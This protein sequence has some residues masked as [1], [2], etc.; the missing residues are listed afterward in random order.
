M[1]KT[2]EVFK[3]FAEAEEADKKYYRSLSPNE[4]IALL[5]ILRDQY[6]PYSHE[7]TEDLREFIELLSE[8]E[9]RFLIVGAFAVAYHGYFRYTSDIDLY[10]TI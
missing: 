10:R 3:S 1:K 6:R 4:R 2:I 8:L 7:L 5:L 9:V